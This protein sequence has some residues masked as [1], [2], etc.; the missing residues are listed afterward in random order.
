MEPIEL[1]N[2]FLVFNK[3]NPYDINSDNIRTLHQ[4]FFDT[5]DQFISYANYYIMHET[6]STQLNKMINQLNFIKS[7]DYNKKFIFINIYNYLIKEIFNKKGIDGIQYDTIYQNIIN[8]L[9]IHVKQI[10][11]DQQS[12]KF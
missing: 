3:F 9:F 2:Y 11:D 7:L 6:D 8:E 10:I 1:Y 5:S 12:R 4:L